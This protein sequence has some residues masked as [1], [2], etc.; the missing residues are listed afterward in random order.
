MRWYLGFF[1]I[2]QCRTLNCYL[3]DLYVTPRTNGLGFCITLLISGLSLQIF[4]F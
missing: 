4:L 1:L 3:C 2:T